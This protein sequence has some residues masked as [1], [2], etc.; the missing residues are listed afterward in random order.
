MY[1]MLEVLKVLL[2][3]HF[4]PHQHFDVCLTNSSNES[5]S[6]EKIKALLTPYQLKYLLLIHAFTGCDTV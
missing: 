3:H 4:T 5:Y 1:C 2:V 6:I